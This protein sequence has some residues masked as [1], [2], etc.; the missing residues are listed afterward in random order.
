M[1]KASFASCYVKQMVFFVRFQ[2]YLSYLHL[3]WNRQSHADLHDKQMCMCLILSSKQSEICQM[4]IVCQVALKFMAVKHSLSILFIYITPGLPV[5]DAGCVSRDL[6]ACLCVFF[7]QYGSMFKVNI[8]WFFTDS[9]G[10]S[11]LKF[12]SES[13]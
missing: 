5:I 12:Y 13:F 6:G 2:R 10:F 4:C 1:L 9:R 11:S 8:W 7:L 3:L